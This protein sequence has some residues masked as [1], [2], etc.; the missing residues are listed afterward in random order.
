MTATT[1]HCWNCSRAYAMSAARCPHCDASNANHDADK[2]YAEK[3]KAVM[4]WPGDFPG[5]HSTEPAA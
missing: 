1:T 2:A 5:A 4:R 3:D